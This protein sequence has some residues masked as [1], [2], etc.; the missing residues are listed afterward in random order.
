MNKQSRRHETMHMVY[1]G[2]ES[3]R[4]TPARCKRFERFTVM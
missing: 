2:D 3:L 1:V 4:E